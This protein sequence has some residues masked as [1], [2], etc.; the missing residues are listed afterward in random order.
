[1]VKIEGLL[2]YYNLGITIKFI[3]L[4]ISQQTNMRFWITEKAL[5]LK[6]SNST[7]ALI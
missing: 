4:T 7:L 2:K 6:F 1:M 5:I 3:V